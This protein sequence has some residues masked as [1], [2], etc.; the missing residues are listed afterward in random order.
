MSNYY[1]FFWVREIKYLLSFKKFPV[2]PQLED[3][4]GKVTNQHYNAAGSW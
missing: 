3:E 1:I 4:K 2:C